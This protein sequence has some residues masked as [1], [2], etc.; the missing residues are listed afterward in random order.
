MKTLIV[1]YQD[2]VRFLVTNHPDYRFMKLQSQMPVEIHNFGTTSVKA[3]D[4]KLRF[5]NQQLGSTEWFRLT[6]EFE[7]Y[8]SGV[9]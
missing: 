6:T 7:Q 8:L 5:A 9:I 3:K 4:I 1:T 2:R